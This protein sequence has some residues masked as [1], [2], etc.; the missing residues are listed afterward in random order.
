[1]AETPAF[2]ELI[3][4]VRA[5]DQDAATLLVRRYEPAIRRAVRFRLADA[6]LGSLLDSMDICQSVLKSFFVRAASGQY[7]LETPEKVM[8]LLAAMARNKLASQARRQGAQRR[9]GLH[10]PGG[11]LDQERLAAPGAGPSR[12]VAARD[13]LQE[14]RRRLS[15]EER[16][17]LDLR[18][19]GHDW[20]AIASRL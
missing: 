18:G 14:V 11:G 3:R 19:E 5:G 8:A 10:D 13:L 6:R 4:R 17:I 15:P 2:D 7:D 1:M 12:V 16:Q 20:A 9:G